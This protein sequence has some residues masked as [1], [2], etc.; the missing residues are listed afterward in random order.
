MEA[1]SVHGIV[2]EAQFAV[3]QDQAAVSTSWGTVTVQQTNMLTASLDVMSNNSHLPDPAYALQI[4]IG[5][6]KRLCVHIEENKKLK[7]VMKSL[8][9][10][11]S[12]VDKEKAKLDLALEEETVLL[13]LLDPINISLGFSRIPFRVKPTSSALYPVIRAATHFYWHL[14]REGSEPRSLSDSVEVEFRKLEETRDQNLDPVLDTKGP[15]LII[16]NRVELKAQQGLMYGIKVTNKLDVALYPFLFFFNNSDFSISERV[17][18]TWDF[19]S[20]NSAGQRHTT[21]RPMAQMEGRLIL[22]SWR[23]HRFRLVMAREVEFH[24]IIY[25]GKVRISISVI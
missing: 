10:E 20:I 7:E 18:W 1:G 4:G 11:V 24:I 6:E 12:L 2:K 13:N 8:D 23:T 9:T 22:P 16:D 3:Y 14:H 17:Y 21:N 5:N 15:N 25:L 19:M